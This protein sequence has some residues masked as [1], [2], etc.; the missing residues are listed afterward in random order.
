MNIY[1]MWNEKITIDK[2]PIPI[3]DLEIS[4]EEGSF[5]KQGLWLNQALFC[6]RRT[7]KA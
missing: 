3:F 4:Q 2:E 6:L 1:L 5:S 7:R